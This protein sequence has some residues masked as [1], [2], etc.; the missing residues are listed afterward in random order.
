MIRG[1]DFKAALGAP[2]AGFNDAVDAALRRVRAGENGG[3][4]R[5]GLRYG[6]AIAVAALAL[7]GVALAVAARLNL[8]E[9]FSGFDHRFAAIPDGNGLPQEA[10]ICFR[11]PEVGETWMRV[12]DAYYD[13]QSVIVGYTLE[14]GLRCESFAPSGEALAGMER[15]EKDMPLSLQNMLVGESQQW[16]EALYAAKARGEAFG[17]TEHVV[18]LSR[19]ELEDGTAVGQNRGEGIV[20]PRGEA[21]YLEEMMEPLPE[22]AQDRDELVFR[23]CLQ[24]QTSHFYTENGIVYQDNEARELGALEVKVRR[25]A[26]VTARYAGTGEFGGAAIEAQARV[27]LVSASLEVAA[28]EDAFDAVQGKSLFV[29]LADGE[30][31]E[32]FLNGSGIVRDGAIAY[33]YSGI[34]HVPERLALYLVT[35]AGNMWEAEQGVGGMEPA[36]TLRKE[37]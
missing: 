16:E 36:V 3:G 18:L 26:G 24:L 11:T 35:D 7:T 21:Y 12:S 8:F 15:L 14:N 22:Q 28:P 37:E 19:F 2:D 27:S 30:T 10:S 31:G 23:L 1:E 32:C 20:N 17:F 29:V 4:A 25:I 13:G 9:A 33:D 34:G 6:L 5:R